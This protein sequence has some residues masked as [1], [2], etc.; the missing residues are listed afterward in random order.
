MTL[1]PDRH[2]KTQYCTHKDTILYLVTVVE[3]L[4]CRQQIHVEAALSD[5]PL[6]P[7]LNSTAQMF[8]N[9]ESYWEEAS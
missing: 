1:Y 4:V 9:W 5:T 3:L 6:L 7:A 8:Q 2:T